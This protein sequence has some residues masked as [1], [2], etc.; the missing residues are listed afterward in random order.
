VRHLK[1]LATH[2]HPSAI[3]ITRRVRLACLL[4]FFPWFNLAN[5]QTIAFADNF[6]GEMGS[7]D[8]IGSTWTTTDTN[9]SGINTLVSNSNSCSLFTRGDEV[10]VTSPT[11]DLSSANSATLTTWVRK[12]DDTISDEP[13]TNDD[14]V[15]EM[16]DDFGNWL[17]LRQFEA[18]EIAEGAE[19]TISIFVPLIMLH[20]STQIRF[21]QLDG[22]GGPPLNGGLGYDYWHID[23]VE[24]T[25]SAQLP[26]SGLSPNS[27][28][29]FEQGL[30]NW[31]ISDASLIGVDSSTSN[32]PSNS[33]FL[34]ADTAT[35][36]SIVID[37][38]TLESF[39][40]WVRRGD[41]DFSE[42]PDT[43]E[44]LTVEFLDASN[45]WNTVETFLGNGTDGEIYDRTYT[46]TA[47][48]RHPNLQLR[49]S[50]ANGSGA[51][52]DYWHVD[53]VCFV[54]PPPILSITKAVE[55]ESEIVSGSSD[56]FLPGAI[57]R[58]T[59]TVTNSGLGEVDDGSMRIADSIDP[60]LEMFV[61]DVDSSGA[62][63]NIVDGTGLNSSGIS[64]N[65]G[66]LSDASDGVVFKNSSGTEII[67]V[68]SYDA[69]VG[70]FELSL[71]GKMNGTG[72]GG[73][74]T[75]DVSF[76]VRLGE[77]KGS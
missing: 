53:D 25:V 32:S 66:G 34:H 24:L 2:L 22:T 56:Y 12:G 30:I 73:T 11:L 31:Y 59:F 4:A 19:E 64:L 27:C 61:G 26:A 15:V 28:D 17:I 54:S 58:Y 23:D 57:V 33:M 16:L 44:D 18:A 46:A 21:R 74:P 6:D 63:F 62:P 9:L 49:L 40:I 50:Y 72:A 41:H 67:P 36:T 65:F 37:G 76:L 3:R 13:D 71:A 39:S 52:T 10:T 14:L 60:R 51:N 7:C 48:M 20:S 35:A 8:V 38:S 43:G 68:G 1:K 5:A 75:F 77:T 69:D 29:D 47:A 42:D 70:S 45:V 55:V